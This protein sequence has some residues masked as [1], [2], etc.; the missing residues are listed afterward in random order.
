MS[1]MPMLHV[2]RQILKAARF[3]PSIKRDHIIAEIK[4][5]FRAKKDLTD[6][7][8]L[9]HA[10]ELAERGLSDLQ[11][12]LPAARDSGGDI[13]VSLKGATGKAFSGRSDRLSGS[14]ENEKP[15]LA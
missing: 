14:T 1:G 8:K 12:Y 5:D 2:Y 15:P 7:D 3:F 6:P 9:S 11:S 4:H 13:S 10:R